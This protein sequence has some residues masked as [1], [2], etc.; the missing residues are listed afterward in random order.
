MLGSNQGKILKSYNL[1]YSNMHCAQC[2]INI[3]VEHSLLLCLWSKKIGE[4]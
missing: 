3:A 4:L 1:K 2:G